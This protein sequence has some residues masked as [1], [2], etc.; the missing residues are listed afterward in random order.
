M[1]MR[2]EVFLSLLLLMG[3][4]I[5]AGAQ[6]F[7]EPPQISPREFALMAWDQSPSD[8]HQLDLMRKAGLNISGF[9]SPGDLDQVHA[10]KMACFVADGRANGYDWSQMPDKKELQQKIDALVAEVRNHPAALG[11]FLRDEPP[12][13]MMPGLGKVAAMLRQEMPGAWAYVNLLPTYANAKQLGADLRSLCTK[14][15]KRSPP[16]AVELRQL[17]AV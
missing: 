2:L 9:C 1:K 17:L 15:H 4:A 13:A 11:F 6:N 8:P 3:A 7:T 14:V 12:T 16:A 5:P 10:A